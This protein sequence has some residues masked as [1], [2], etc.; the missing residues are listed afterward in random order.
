M[1]ANINLK[2]DENV[3]EVTGKSNLNGEIVS[4]ADLRG[5]AALVLAGLCAKGTTR[6]ENAEYILRGYENLEEKLNKLGAHIKLE[7]GGIDAK[8]SCKC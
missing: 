6:V 1:G 5:G 7:K 2:E 3:I 8:E 4:S